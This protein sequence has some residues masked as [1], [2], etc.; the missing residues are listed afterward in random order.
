MGVTAGNIT[1]IIGRTSFSEAADALRKLLDEL[2]GKGAAAEP[3]VGQGGEADQE[4]K[5]EVDVSKKKQGKT[6]KAGGK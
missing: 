3:N 5:P 2:E 1:P 6:G 4:L